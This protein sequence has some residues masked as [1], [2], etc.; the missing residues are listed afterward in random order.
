LIAIA[1][2]R[3]MCPAC[4][5]TAAWIAASLASTG[6]LATIAIRAFSV[7]NAVDNHL[8]SAPSNLSGKENGQER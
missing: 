4:L 6:G 3:T 7:K 1:K 2:E 5:A 8:D